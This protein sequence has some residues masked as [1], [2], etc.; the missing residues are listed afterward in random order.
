VFMFSCEQQGLLHL[1]A[2]C[3]GTVTGGG[4]PMYTCLDRLYRL[5][6]TAGQHQTEVKA[7]FPAYH[8]GQLGLNPLIHLS[9][10]PG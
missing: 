4:F 10:Q 1:I 6:E 8:F 5:Q 3:D 2:A 7:P 9:T